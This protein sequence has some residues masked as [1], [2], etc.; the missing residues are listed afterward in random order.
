MSLTK[1]ENPTPNH[2]TNPE[3]HGFTIKYTVS[4]TI[5]SY[6]D[7]NRDSIELHC[8]T[9]LMPTLLLIINALSK[10]AKTLLSHRGIF[11]YS[12]SLD[13]P[14]FNHLPEIKKVN[15]ENL[16]SAYLSININKR[17]YPEQYFLIKASRTPKCLQII[18]SLDFYKHLLYFQDAHKLLPYIHKYESP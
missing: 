4:T 11:A 14:P 13:K 5:V 15:I 12:F 17:A 2:Y 1:R 18:I 6:Q 9:N 3:L 8:P 10:H 16:T 7:C